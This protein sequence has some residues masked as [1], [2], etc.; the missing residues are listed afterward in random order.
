MK[1]IVTF[2]IPEPAPTPELDE[3]EQIESCGNAP[4]AEKDLFT[5]V[6]TEA[7]KQALENKTGQPDSPLGDMLQDAQRPVN[8]YDA[9]MKVT[10]IPA[11]GA[12]DWKKC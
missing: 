8:N 6:D 1:I 11:F 10:I 3:T 7:V 9:E 12:G 2:T 5:D 4:A